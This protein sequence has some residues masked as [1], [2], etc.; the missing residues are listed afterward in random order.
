MCPPA[1]AMKSSMW[2]ELIEEPAARTRSPSCCTAKC[3]SPGGS[4]A[5]DGEATGLMPVSSSEHSEMFGETNG[6]LGIVMSQS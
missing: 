4:V 1:E 5:V 6:E 2:R 3:A